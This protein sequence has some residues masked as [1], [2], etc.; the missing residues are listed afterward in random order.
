VVRE[1]AAR[2]G[3]RHLRARDGHR[4]LVVA[5]RARS[6]RDSERHRQ[7][8]TPTTM[9]FIFRLLLWVSG[10]EESSRQ[11]GPDWS[12]SRPDAP[13]VRDSRS[14]S[15]GKLRRYQVHCA[16]EE[17]SCAAPSSG[18]AE[19]YVCRTRRP[20]RARRDLSLT[21]EAHGPCTAHGASDMRR[22]GAGQIAQ[23]SSVAPTM[24]PPC[25]RRAARSSPER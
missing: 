12:R 11:R 18:S 8:A 2:A 5:L 7:R 24:R 17:S 1:A 19:A 14:A 16:R 4:G 13:R 25:Q 9:S 22:H 20:S 10:G 6:L 21:A 15:T 3:G 23:V